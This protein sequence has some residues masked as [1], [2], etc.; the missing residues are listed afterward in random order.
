M[1]SPQLIAEIK[2]DEAYRSHAYRD[3]EGILTIGYGLNL[4]DG[5]SEPLAAKI[6]EFI[7]EERQDNLSRLLPFWQNLTPARREV[8]INMAYNLGIP[9]FLKFRD[10][11]TAAGAGDVAGV[12]REMRDSRWYKQVGGRAEKLIEKYRLG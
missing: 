8:F 3:T 1:P 2:R 9:R 6:L 12:C 10:M 5:I 4:D 7:V 11:L